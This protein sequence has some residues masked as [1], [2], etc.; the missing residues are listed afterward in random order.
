MRAVSHIQTN[1]YATL[2]LIYVQ[3]S[4][5]DGQISWII[6]TLAHVK[7]TF[8][9]CTAGLLCSCSISLCCSGAVLKNA[10]VTEAYVSGATNMTP[11]DI[12]GAGE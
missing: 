2:C 10:V 3:W 4:P 5:R 9:D 12:E 8:L 6:T 11:A 7:A 1:T